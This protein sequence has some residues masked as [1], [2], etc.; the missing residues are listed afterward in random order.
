VLKVL[1][2][3][4]IST[5]HQDQ[6]SLADQQALLERYVRD[7][8]EGPVEWTIISSQDS[9][10]YLDREESARAEA[11]VETRTQDLVIAEDLARLYRRAKAYDF[12]ELCQDCDTRLIAIN[13]HVD[14]GRNDWHLSAL[15]SV[16]RHES[17]NRDT[18]ERIRRSLRHRFPQ[19][20]VFQ[21][22]I[23][24][25]VKPENAKSDAEV[26]KDPAAEAVYDEWFRR[27]EHGASFA[28]VADWLNKLGI[29]TGPYCRGKRWTGVMV[30]RITRNPILKGIRVRNAKVSRRINK[31][32]RR[33]SVKAP[34]S[35]R[36]ERY[37]AHLVF[38]EPERWD[39]VVRLVDHRNAK[40]CR[41]G[42]NGADPRNGVPKK[43]TVWPGQHLACGVCGRPYYWSG[44]SSTHHMMCS[45]S[46]NYRCWNAVLLNGEMAAHRLVAAIVAEIR[47]LPDFDDHFFAQVQQRLDSARRVQ[48]DQLEKVEQQ[49]RE[50][51]QQIAKVTDSIAVLSGSRALLD[52]LR[53]LE[54]KRDQLSRD[55][56]AQHASLDEEIALPSKEAIQ[57]AAETVFGSFTPQS[58]EIGRLMQKLLP[59]LRVYPYRLCDGGAVVLRAHATLHLACLTLKASPLGGSAGVLQREIVVDLFDPPQREMY[60]ERV[61]VLRAEGLSERQVAKQLGI[62]V[63]AAQ[64]AAALDRQMNQLGITDPYLAVAEP[65]TDYGKLRRHRHSRYRFEP[66]HGGASGSM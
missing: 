12:C 46:H 59:D 48:T 13:D 66:S 21:F 45:G 28:E 56:D 51:D 36:L 34:P 54:A 2:I 11:L 7:H 53:E 52:K 50:V 43:Q 62:T 40:Y 6:R 32:G 14:T 61:V 49:R 33:R 22:S 18:S 1:G 10:E 41:T 60:R 15:F 63:T 24:G 16:F 20:L 5:V 19:G 17:Y 39:R 35:E 27:L 47:T 3:T 4:R 37:C 31:T 55:V 25:Y 38:I 30:G 44:K 26:S 42:V 57:R 58:P 9:G 8:Y 23:Y 29:P 64:R 65:P